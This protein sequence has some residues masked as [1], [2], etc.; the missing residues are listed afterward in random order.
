MTM[1]LLVSVLIGT[2]LFLAATGCSGNGQR[3]GNTTSVRKIV[4]ADIDSAVNER[5]LVNRATLVV[6]GSPT[7]E[8]EEKVTTNDGEFSAYYQTVRVHEVLMGKTADRTVRVV[9]TGVSSKMKDNYKDEDGL[10]GALPQGRM[11]LFLQPSAEPGVM[12]V[13]GHFSGEM[14]LDSADKVSSLVDVKTFKGLEVAAVRKR[15]GELRSK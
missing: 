8:V 4:S 15:V 5:D 3:S 2:V 14:V 1:R 6:V 7:G 11:I 12:Q 13:V 9:R 10:R